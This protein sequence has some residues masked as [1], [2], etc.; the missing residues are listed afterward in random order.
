[1]LPRLCLASS[2]VS[3]S[4][5]PRPT[6]ALTT[7]SASI[8]RSSS[9]NSINRSSGI[10]RSKRHWPLTSSPSFLH[11]VS[12]LQGNKQRQSRYISLLSVLN[13]HRSFSSRNAVV[14]SYSS[15]GVILDPYFEHAAKEKAAKEI[16]LFSVR[17]LQ[18]RWAGIKAKLQ[19]GVSF[20]HIRK[21]AKTFEL[22][23]FGKLAQ[24]L[25]IDFHEAY[26]K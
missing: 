25:F 11:F 6:L 14:D 1:M 16:S 20:G 5:F 4:S 3:T 8:Y 7:V 9:S 23:G 19:S 13:S 22:K 24:S 21:H 12:S 17:G 2:R 10:G 15:S 26:E 18:N